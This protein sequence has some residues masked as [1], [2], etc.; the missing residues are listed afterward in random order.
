MTKRD[1]RGAAAIEFVVILPALVLMIALVVAGG[2]VAHARLTVG[3]LAD[4]AARAASLA[5]TATAAHTDA[6]A[7]ATADATSLG[8]HCTGGLNVSVDTSGFSVPV[9]Q[10]A[11][12]QATVRCRV[13]FS[14]LLAPG[15]P[16]A[17]ELEATAAST[18]DRYR[19]R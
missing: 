15:L 7:V 5:R 10:P 2:R 4:A 16:G 13:G 1:E 11:N 6:R 8:L 17:I 12:T 18:L 14:D 3:Q 19:G 9:G